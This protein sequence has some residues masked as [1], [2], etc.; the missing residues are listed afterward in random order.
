MAQNEAALSAFIAEGSPCECGYAD[1]TGTLCT[2]CFQ[3]WCK[4]HDMV[5]YYQQRWEGK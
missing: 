2:D 5:A 1:A 3:Q 4:D